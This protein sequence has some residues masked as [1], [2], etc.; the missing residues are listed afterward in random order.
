M[1]S[2]CLLVEED[3]WCRIPHQK[4]V[5]Y[6]RLPRSQDKGPWW[7]KPVGSVSQ[8]SSRSGRHHKENPK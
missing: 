1:G 3:C 7:I 2:C 5:T 6:Q 4:S 8:G